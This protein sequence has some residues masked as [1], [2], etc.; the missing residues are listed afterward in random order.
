M[1]RRASCKA[2]VAE[3][4]RS[5][6]TFPVATAISGRSSN[7]TASAA[8]CSSSGR[9]PF[10]SSTTTST[11]SAST[12]MSTVLRRGSRVSKRSRDRPGIL[13]LAADAGSNATTGAVVRAINAEA[14]KSATSG[15]APK[16]TTYP[17]DLV[18]KRTGRTGGTSHS[19][20]PFAAT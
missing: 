18:G 11:S 19:L 15:S 14:R 3:S 1:D 2:E 12:A 4:T 7:S 16:S 8:A 9:Q 13:V 6:N 5:A 17:H 20:G 10:E